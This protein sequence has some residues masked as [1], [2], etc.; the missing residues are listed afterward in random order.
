MTTPT[1]DQDDWRSD[2]RIDLIKSD[3]AGGT[4]LV[5]YQYCVSIVILSFRRSSGVKV[6]RPGQSSVIP[7]LPY[8]LISLLAGWWGVPWGPFWTIQTVYRNLRGGIDASGPAREAP[9]SRMAILSG[10]SL[11]AADRSFLAQASARMTQAGTPADVAA[12][13][14]SS[15]ADALSDPDPRRA[16]ERRSAVVAEGTRNWPAEARIALIRQLEE[17]WSATAGDDADWLQLPASV[18]AS[19]LGQGALMSLAVLEGLSSDQAEVER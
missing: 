16:L 5:V 15:Y 1:R 6:I 13:A 4:K 10:Q 8:T 11:L 18:R 2:P 19:Y 12:A 3:L 9:E 14:I 17:P 7:G